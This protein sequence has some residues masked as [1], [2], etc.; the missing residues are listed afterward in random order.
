M[1]KRHPAEFRREVLDL[2]AAGRPVA[3]VAPELAISEQSIYVWRLQEPIDAGQL[4]GTISREN[5]ELYAARERMAETRG[6]GRDP[7]RAAQSLG[8]VVSPKALG[9]DRRDGLGETA[10]PTRLPSARRRRIR[11]L[12]VAL[13]ACGCPTPRAR[14]LNWDSLWDT[15]RA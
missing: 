14:A 8:E 10:G 5:A 3:Q 2:L 4:P 13:P 12:R 6:R 9:A 1:P 7:R 11:L 15:A